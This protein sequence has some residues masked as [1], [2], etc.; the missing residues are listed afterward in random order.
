VGR[1][2]FKQ[3]YALYMNA[4]VQLGR[5]EFIY[6]IEGCLYTHASMELQS[7]QRLYTHARG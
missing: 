6:W 3:R 5:S 4:R 7:H 1:D 2:V